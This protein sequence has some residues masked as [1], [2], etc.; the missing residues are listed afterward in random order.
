MHSMSY[1]ATSYRRSYFISANM[2]AG[3]IDCA[4][5]DAVEMLKIQSDGH[6]FNN[7]NNN[8]TLPSYPY[9]YNRISSSDGINGHRRPTAVRK[10]FVHI[11]QRSR[12]FFQLRRSRLFRRK[13]LRT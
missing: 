10:N 2:D 6:M 1:D 7:N 3:T 11:R 4:I 13:N 9:R 12:S 8:N 5:K